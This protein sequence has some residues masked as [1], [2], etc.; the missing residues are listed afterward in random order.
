MWCHH[1]QR[2]K[3][4]LKYCPMLP[5]W[6]RLISLNCMVY[7]YMLGLTSIER[8]WY[9]NKSRSRNYTNNIYAT[10]YCPKIKGLW[11]VGNSENTQKRQ[12]LVS[13]WKLLFYFSAIIPIR[14]CPCHRYV[15]ATRGLESI[16]GV[17][18]ACKRSPSWMHGT[19]HNL[20]CRISNKCQ[21]QIMWLYVAW[22]IIPKNVKIKIVIYTI[23]VRLNSNR[24]Y[25]IRSLSISIISLVRG[26]VARL[27]NNEITY[28][29][30]PTIYIY[31]YHYRDAKNCL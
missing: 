12:T 28:I 11:I 19:K 23:K 16:P 7:I 8:G 13:G 2:N 15:I 14:A 29:A 18:G 4:F 1:R 6:G 20:T 24:G 27:V 17:K 10:V 26:A 31:I 30:W 21:F 5:S 3:W 22:H 9:K 25:E